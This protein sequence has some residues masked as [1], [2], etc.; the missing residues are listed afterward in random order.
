MDYDEHDPHSKRI[1]DANDWRSFDITEEDIRRSRRAY[2]AN[3]SYLDE[4]IGELLQTLE[5]AGMADIDHPV[6]SPTTATCWAS[7]GCGSR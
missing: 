2:F 6:L 7:A 1:F 4:K 3:I 5:D